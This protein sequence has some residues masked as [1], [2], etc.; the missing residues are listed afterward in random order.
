MEAQV[1]DPAVSGVPV[2]VCASATE[3]RVQGVD[4]GFPEAQ[5]VAM[6]AGN[7][8]NLQPDAAGGDLVSV[9]HRAAHLSW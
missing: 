7:E 5:P 1:G 6:R 3:K 8:G 9:D 4:R 2:T